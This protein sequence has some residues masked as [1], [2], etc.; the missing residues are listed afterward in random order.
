MPFKNLA[1]TLTLT[2]AIGLVACSPRD[3]PP[4]EES[5]SGSPADTAAAAT[6]SPPATGNASKPLQKI[7]LTPGNGAE[8][9]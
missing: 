5:A 2:T 6:A 4:A 3:K 7:E 9:K 1:V 8:I